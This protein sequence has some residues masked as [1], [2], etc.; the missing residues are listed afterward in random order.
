MTRTHEGSYDGRHLRIA[1]VA[2]RFNETIS[3]RLVDGAL[4]CLRRHGVDDDYVSLAWV[5]GAFE[6]PVTAKRIA[7]SGE[8]DAVVCVGAVIRGD[9]AHFDFVASHAMNGIGRAG[10]ETGVPIL[11]GVLTTDTVEQAADRAGGKMGNK[12]F[13]AALAALE[14]ANL[15]A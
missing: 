4:D 3:R 15:F 1:V 2:S 13:E 12:G 10:L 7:S 14:M 8:V 6:L 11:A 5:P 9:T